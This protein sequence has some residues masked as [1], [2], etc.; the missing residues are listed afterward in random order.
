M[1]PERGARPRYRRFLGDWMKRVVTGAML[2]AGLALAGPAMA[3]PAQCSVTGYDTFDC[4]VAFDG[5][6]LT[7][8]L[9]DGGIFAFT[10]LEEDVGTAFMVAPDARPGQRPRELHQF[11][12]VADRPG[13]WAREAEFE[14]CVLVQQ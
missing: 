12:P 13:C 1:L 7:F 6:G 5:G 9:P 11:S 8:E 10:L 4:D 2:V 3:M 14:F